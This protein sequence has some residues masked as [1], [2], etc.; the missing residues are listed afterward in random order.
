MFGVGKKERER[1]RAGFALGFAPSGNTARESRAPASKVTALIQCL[2]LAPPKE[3]QA[4]D[5]KPRLENIGI[6]MQNT[7]N[8]VTNKFTGLRDWENQIVRD[9]SL[10]T[11]SCQCPDTHDSFRGK[12][13]L[14]CKMG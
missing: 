11:F 2:G 3:L 13:L 8:T 5:E 10:V 14:D 9:G 6:L 12:G 4:L 7:I 1:S